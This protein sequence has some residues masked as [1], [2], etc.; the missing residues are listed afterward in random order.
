MNTYKSSEH[1][2]ILSQRKFLNWSVM[3][4]GSNYLKFRLDFYQ[5]LYC[6]LFH[7]RGL[8]FINYGNLRYLKPFIQNPDLNLF[9]LT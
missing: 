2:S 5:Y 7:T 9:Y 6:M 4:S 1:I 3:G 8:V